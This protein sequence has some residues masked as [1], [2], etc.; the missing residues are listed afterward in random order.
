MARSRIRDVVVVL[1]GITGSVLQKDGVDVWAISGRAIAKALFSLGDSL[2]ELQIKGDDP[3]IDDLGDG[4]RATGLMPDA[5]LVPGL[6]KID[7]YSSLTRLITERF[8]VAPGSAEGNGPANF[9]EFPYDWRR[10]NRVAARKL[11]RL[12]DKHLPRWR[13]YSGAKDA[14]VILLA[15]SM[16]GLVSRYYLDC[17][18][19]WRDCRALVTFGTR[20]RGSV[21]A[22]GF[23]ANGYK[24]AFVDLTDVLRSYMSVYQLLPIYPMLSVG[25]EWKRIAEVGKLP[26]VDPVASKAA[27]EFHRDIEAA[28]KER[29]R[30][31]GG[32]PIIPFVGVCQSTLQS[33]RLS[34]DGIE[35][36]EKVPSW[37]DSRLEDGDGTVPRLSAIPIELSN[38][39]RDTFAAGRHASLQRHDQILRDLYQRITQM[40]VQGLEAI[41]EPEERPD[42][43]QRAALSVDLDDVYVAG[44]PVT[45]RARLLNAAEPP[46]GLIARIAPVD[47]PRPV[48][49][50]AFNEHSD[51][52]RLEIQDRKPGLYRVEVRT[53]KAGPQA[54][55]PIEDLF[56]VAR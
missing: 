49:D 4:I 6:V 14:K 19:G 56:E 23:L 41:R 51:G 33:A 21:N 37:I 43:E 36:T 38:A 42:L 1:P 31:G 40:Q 55:T 48:G 8:E 16:G 13:E 5:H 12:V 30:Q 52:W 47:P 11:K 2:R 34:G 22:L 35:V 26:G 18:D 29:E 54:P 3:E 27:L 17:L 46:D 50:H 20:Y 53:R 32:Y 44:E 24:E 9:F 15:H 28:V 39:F 10:D 45:L 25:E 7:G